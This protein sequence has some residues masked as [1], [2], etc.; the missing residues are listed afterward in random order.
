[1]TPVREDPS[2]F[3]S[4]AYGPEYNELLSLHEA[5]HA[6]IGTMLGIRIEAVYT[7]FEYTPTGMARIRQ[8]C[9]I[10]PTSS[11][12]MSVEDKVLLTAGGPAAELMMNGRWDAD[13]GKVDRAQLQ[14]IG[15]W[16]FE[17]CV[18]AAVERLQPNQNLLLAMR[19]QIK[20]SMENLKHCKLT[21]GGTHIILLGGGE[22]K[23][24]GRVLGSPVESGSVRL[25][26]AKRRL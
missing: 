9:K 5:G 7:T 24:L 20:L 19:Q 8:H 15:I 17:Y 3:T 14:E 21:R 22:I 2:L 4:S 11:K 26:I 12:A 25:E 1:M 6:T 16:N 10:G 23:R 18:D 13:N